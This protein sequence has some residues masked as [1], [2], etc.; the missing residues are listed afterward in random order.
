MPSMLHIPSWDKNCPISQGESHDQ[1]AGKSHEKFA[2]FLIFPYREEALSWHRN[3]IQD[4]SDPI[5]E[6]ALQTACD[7][8]K[9]FPDMEFHIDSLVKGRAYK[10]PFLVGYWNHQEFYLEVWNEPDY[11]QERIA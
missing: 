9:E 11:K 4:Y 2:I 3:R 5:P 1:V 6:F 10:D 8:K 7:M